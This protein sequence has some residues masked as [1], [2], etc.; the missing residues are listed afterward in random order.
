LETVD[1]GL[2]A[3]AQRSVITLEDIC[4]PADSKVTVGS[5]VAT[6]WIDRD[7]TTAIDEIRGSEPRHHRQSDWRD[8]VSIAR[9][10]GNPAQTIMN[11]ARSDSLSKYR[12]R[13]G[14]L[15]IRHLQWLIPHP[16]YQR[17]AL[18]REKEG[19]SL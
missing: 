2:I 11:E 19:Y 5:G 13:M 6:L 8:G 18:G 7:G 16:M 9:G 3:E 10:V 15:E 1:A 4:P 12:Q 14:P 17:R